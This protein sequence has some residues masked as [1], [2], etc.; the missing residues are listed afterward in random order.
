MAQVSPMILC[1]RGLSLKWTS[2]DSANS[3]SLENAFLFGIE[4]PD[5]IR[6]PFNIR[7]D[8]MGRLE[9]EWPAGLGAK[10]NDQDV[11][12]TSQ[13]LCAEKIIWKQ[14]S[15]STEELLA[16]FDLPNHEHL[17]V[18]IQATT[19]RNL[20]L[21]LRPLRLVASIL[22][23]HILLLGI[24]A[25]DLPQREPIRPKILATYHLMDAPRSSAINSTH[26]SGLSHAARSSL[27]SWSVGRS[28]T[29]LKN[30][31]SMAS[32][33]ETPRHPQGKID[34]GL[35]SKLQA[36]ENTE[37][38]PLNISSEEV[39]KL[40]NAI[41][42]QLKTCYDDAL[43]LDRE[44][45]GNPELHLSVSAKGRVDQTQIRNISGRPH[46]VAELQ[47]CFEREFA[48]V[49]FPKANQDF[50]VRQSLILTK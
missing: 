16:T 1:P 38:T 30:W 21:K 36:Y 32:A 6:A 8:L 47:R 3:S 25:V 17:Q 27:K 37:S 50:S 14:E 22:V 26:S 42:P 5:P 12:I 9:I 23:G 33:P 20:L 49:I 2:P 28:R 43:V 39:R 45:R 7:Q 40:V 13:Y 11:A 44:L 34:F 24:A 31:T 46:A 18:R 15:P 29:S 4:R 41:Q 35:P 48:S 10:I 19:W